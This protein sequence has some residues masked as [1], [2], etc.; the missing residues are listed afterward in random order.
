MQYMETHDFVNATMSMDA[1]L[2]D[3]EPSWM[4]QDVGFD[5]SHDHSSA[6]DCESPPPCDSP[7]QQD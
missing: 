4:D 2:D 3:G 6:A 1:A 5:A 7:G